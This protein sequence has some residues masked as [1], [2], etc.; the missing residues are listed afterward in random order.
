MYH[1]T[2][3]LCLALKMKSLTVDTCSCVVDRQTIGQ[4]D[5]S[6]ADE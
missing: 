4:T 5:R 3:F 1:E 2:H 6:F